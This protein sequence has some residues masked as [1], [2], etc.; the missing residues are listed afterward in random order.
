MRQADA[1][2]KTFRVNIRL[3]QTARITGICLEVIRSQGR[4]LTSH[5]YPSLSH[6]CNMIECRFMPAGNVEQF[7]PGTVETI[8]AVENKTYE[9]HSLWKSKYAS[10]PAGSFILID[11]SAVMLMDSAYSLSL[12]AG[13]PFTTGYVDGEALSAR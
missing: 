3:P 5:L 13:H 8:T 1:C 9:P 6:S 10:D 7:M 12:L 2:Q 11:S 4:E